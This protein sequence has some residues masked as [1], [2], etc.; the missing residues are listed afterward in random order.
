MSTLL[1]ACNDLMDELG[2]ARPGPI[3]G[4][5]DPNARKLLAAAKRTGQELWRRHDWSVLHRE[6]PFDT[7]NGK[8]NYTLPDDW[9]RAI[10]GTA[11]DRTNY[12]R[13]RGNLTPQQW[14][15]RR[16][17]LVASAANRFAYR[18]LA[19]SRQG[20]L[21]LDPV[22]S[23]V[24]SLVIEYVSSF[25][26]E[27]EDGNPFE[28]FTADAQY[29]RMDAELFQLG[30]GWRGRKAF[31]FSYADDQAEYDVKVRTAI[32]QDLQLPKVNS[33]PDLDHLP[34]ANIPEGNWAQ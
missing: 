23:G 20:S 31:G 13:V 3:V 17:G 21:L 6:H 1:D 18:T 14:Q 29:P 2:L 5:A 24:N 12:W 8:D 10:G 22:P 28:N 34:M 11:W 9:G 25:W 32:T 30:L 4:S 19:G 15:V 27:D 16:S 33:A 26:V 7:A